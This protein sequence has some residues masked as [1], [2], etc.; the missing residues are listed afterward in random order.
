MKRV[1]PYVWNTLVEC[2]LKKADFLI[3]QLIKILIFFSIIKKI[4][5]LIRIGLDALIILIFTF[6]VYDACIKSYFQKTPSLNRFELYFS[7]FSLFEQ[8]LKPKI[9]KNRCNECGLKLKFRKPVLDI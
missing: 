8:K 1:T 7:Y 4:S 2:D 3:S 9:E 5:F 6:M